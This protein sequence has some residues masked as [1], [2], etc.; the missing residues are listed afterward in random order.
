MK[1]ENLLFSATRVKYTATLPQTATKMQDHTT[2]EHVLK[3]LM[4][5][6]PAQTVKKRILLISP[7]ARALLAFLA[8]RNTRTA[9][10][11]QP[12]LAQHIPSPQDFPGL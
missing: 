6:Q 2:P 10:Y 7:N 5:L 1:P 3:P 11:Q 4:F 8:K 12:Y 9:Q